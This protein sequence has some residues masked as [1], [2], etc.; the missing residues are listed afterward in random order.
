[1]KTITDRQAVQEVL[2]ATKKHL[3]TLKR[4]KTILP[5]GYSHLNDVIDG[6]S[7]SIAKLKTALKPAPVRTQTVYLLVN[8]L[9]NRPILISS[10]SQF[11]RRRIAKRSDARTVVSLTPAEIAKISKECLD[12]TRADE[13]AAVA[14]DPASGV[15]A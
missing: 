11:V 13:A 14:T 8:E 7:I 1:M 12:H 6:L 4:L 5:F 9:T 15:T 10:D 3:S 2:D